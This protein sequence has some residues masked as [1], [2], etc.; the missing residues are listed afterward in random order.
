MKNNREK[1]PVIGISATL[2]TIESG[3][4]QGCERT[5]VIHDYIQA[6]SL[7]GG[8]P[9]VLPIIEGE[10]QI[11]QQM[12]LVDGLL[13]SGGFDV[14][15]LFYDEEPQKGL[16]A[17]CFD[18]DVYEMQLIEIAK[19][20][21]KP[22]FGICRGLQLL[23]VALG[24]TLYQDIHLYLASA[25]QHNQKAK[26]NEAVHHVHLIQETK[27]QEIFEEEV[28]VTNSFHH[29]A[30][31]DLAPNLTVN[32]YSIDGIIEG[33]EGKEDDHFILAVQWHPELMINKHP[34][35]LKLFHAFVEAAQRSRK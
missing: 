6:V 8:A 1:A 16:E 15:P 24:G 33:I 5:T 20:S 28:I 29:Q 9:I 21:R 32:A 4:F 13:L 22:I 19:R 17:I 26:V 3:C 23:N 30:I 35:M 14:S 10:S 25:L 12:S 11:E 31:K 18:R 34:T 2:L 7:A 27:L